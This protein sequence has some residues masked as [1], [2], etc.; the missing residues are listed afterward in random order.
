MSD[1]L[2]ALLRP[3]RGE[4][5]RRICGFVTL[6]VAIPRLPLWDTPPLFSPLTIFPPVVFGWLALALGI[7]LLVTNGPRRPMFSGRLVAFIGLVVWALLA[8]ATDSVTSI[9]I[10]IIIMWAMVGEIGASSNDV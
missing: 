2:I 7:A 4:D 8:G 10:D 3:F 1:R 9:L 5:V 6:A